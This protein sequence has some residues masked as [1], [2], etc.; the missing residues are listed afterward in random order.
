MTRHMVMAHVVVA[1]MPLAYIVVAYGGMACIAIGGTRHHLLP[2]IEHTC[3]ASDGLVDGLDRGPVEHL[4]LVGGA[5][6]RTATEGDPH[7]PPSPI[8]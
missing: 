6:H 1:S 5:S 7:L 8:E 3:G 2:H 4:K